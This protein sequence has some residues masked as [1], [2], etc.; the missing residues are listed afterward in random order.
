MGSTD[1]LRH[2]SKN[3]II[4]QRKFSLSFIPS[5]IYLMMEFRKQALSGLV[6]KTPDL[7]M[8]NRLIH[9]VHIPYDSQLW[10]IN[11]SSN[12]WKIGTV[13]GVNKEGKAKKCRI[14]GSGI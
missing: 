4:L 6:I 9:K 8:L 3:I 14:Q 11:F 7:L 5:L 12:I 1:K 2:Y 10:L 13:V